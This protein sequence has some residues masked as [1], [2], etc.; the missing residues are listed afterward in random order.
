MGGEEALQEGKAGK[1][2]RQA[3]Q[4]VETVKISAVARDLGRG[5]GEG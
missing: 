4:T 3:G 1:Q 5:G 2:D